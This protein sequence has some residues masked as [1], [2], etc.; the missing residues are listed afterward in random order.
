MKKYVTI[1]VRVNRLFIEKQSLLIHHSVLILF[2]KGRFTCG[3]GRLKRNLEAHPVSASVNK[4][5]PKGELSSDSSIW[6]TAKQGPKTN[7]S[8]SNCVY[9]CV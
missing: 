9:G 4:T 2:V 3:L 8:S 5:E 7:P 1:I 6:I